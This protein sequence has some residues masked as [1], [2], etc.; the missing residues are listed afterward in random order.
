MAA[1]HPRLTFEF[2]AYV[3]NMPPHWRKDNHT[4]DWRQS[5]FGGESLQARMWA[6]G[7]V[8]SANAS[9]KLLDDR[10]D[11]AQKKT[12]PWPE[13]AET[14]CFACHADLRHPSWRRNVVYPERQKETAKPEAKRKKYHV[15]EFPYSVWFTTLLPTLTGSERAGLRTNL[16]NLGDLMRQ[17]LDPDK[18]EDLQPVRSQVRT[19]LNDLKEL[20]NAVAGTKYNAD[21]IKKMLGQASSG[22][23]DKVVPTMNWEEAEQ[24]M[25][26]VYALRSSLPEDV[27]KKLD[28]PLGKAT[29]LL[30]YPP[31]SDSPADFRRTEELNKELNQALSDLRKALR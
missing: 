26:M 30:A 6:L 17:P 16:L 8:E 11:R 28:E 4:K 3:D 19:S 2:A 1:G 25:L 12:G 9:L 10:A 22:P 21:T 15:G 18:P 5:A 29:R 20:R 31:R 7:Q 14:D 13:F 24:Y 27:R 23:D